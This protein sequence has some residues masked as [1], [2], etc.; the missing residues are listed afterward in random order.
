MANIRKIIAIACIVIAVLI[1]I[2]AGALLFLN[3]MPSS[4]TVSPTPTTNN[5][6]T[7]TATPQKT[8]FQGIYVFNGNNASTFSDNPNIAGTYLGYYWSDLEPQQGQYNWS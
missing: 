6:P 2:G 7:P 5:T 4:T 8:G 1:V 3:K